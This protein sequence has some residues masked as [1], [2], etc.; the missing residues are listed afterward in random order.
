MGVSEH[1]QDSIEDLGDHAEDSVED[2]F[3]HVEGKVE[4]QLDAKAREAEEKKEQEER[5]QRAQQRK[6]NAQ[7]SSQQQTPPAL[8][9]A[10][11]APEDLS[12]FAYAAVFSS[13]LAMFGLALRSR[14][15]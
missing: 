6:E 3:Q 8:A 11:I 4:R 5:E 9:L 1:M 14:F 12:S 15:Q 7:Q 10:A 2:F 13:A